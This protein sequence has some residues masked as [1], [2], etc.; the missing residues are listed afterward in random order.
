MSELTP[1]LRKLPKKDVL[2]QWTDNH[3]KA[4]QELKSRVRFDACLQYSDTTK[5]VTLQVDASKAGLGAVLMQKDSQGRSR[6][7]ALSSKSIIPAETRYANIKCEMV[8][9]V[10]A[11]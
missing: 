10:F 2:L 1:N 3:E 6:P 5:P 11:A 4:F 9:V 8:T 7:V